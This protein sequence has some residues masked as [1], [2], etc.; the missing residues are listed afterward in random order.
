MNSVLNGECFSDDGVSCD[1]KLTSLATTILG[2]KNK[3]VSNYTSWISNQTAILTSLDWF[4]QI[5][6]SAVSSC[7]VNN[8]QESYI[9]KINSNKKLTSSDSSS[10]FSISGNYW[11]K[12]SPSCYDEEINISCNSSFSTGLFFKNSTSAEINL[13]DTIKSASSGKVINEKIK[14]YCFTEGTSCEYE[15]SLWSS[16]AMD[17]SGEDTSLYFPYLISSSGQH[18]EYIPDS[19]IFYLTN[20]NSFKTNLISLQN[21]AGYWNKSGDAYFDTA[22]S[23]FFLP[24]D[25]PQKQLSKNWLLLNQNA[26]GCWNNLSSSGLM[27][28]AFILASIWPEYI[29]KESCG[30]GFLE[31]SEECDGTKLRGNDCAIILNDENATGTLSC[32]PLGHANQCTFD[33]SNC[34]GGVECSDSNPCPGNLTCSANGKCVNSSTPNIECVRDGDCEDDEE[35]LSNICVEKTKLDCQTEGYFC[36]SKSACFKID[37]NQLGDYTCGNSLSYCCDRNEFSCS[38]SGGKICPSGQ[39]CDGTI[40]GDNCCIDGECVSD[41]QNSCENNLGTCKASCSDNEYESSFYSCD[42]SSQICCMEE[43]KD[44]K[45]LLI[46]GLIILI[47]LALVI[48]L[49]KFKDKIFKKKGTE[50]GNPS[51]SLRPVFPQRVPQRPIYNPNRP[52]RIPSSVSQRVPKKR[53]KEFD[54]VLKKLRDIGK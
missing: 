22:L 14:S 47:V 21:S 20:E 6:S 43:Q 37:G 33:I 4:L 27:D 41:S 2:I 46:I 10:C 11:L 48:V 16:I 49:V 52:R 30:N 1:L 45:K 25:S 24:E 51:N 5:D 44:N 36:M 7:T 19:F 18:Q 32:Y 35:C 9:I 42:S 53:T 39:I 31:S 13:L 38:S 17:V 15:P 34:V 3:D 29:P 23:L 40:K 8:S 12:I 28:T 54:D 50:K 26:D